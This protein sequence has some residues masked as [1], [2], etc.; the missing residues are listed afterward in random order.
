M[1]T[2]NILPLEGSSIIKV[3]PAKL[4]AGKV[5]K[6]LLVIFVLSWISM[7]SSCVVAVPHERY[8][9]HTIVVEQEYR[10]E[11]HDNG[12]HKGWYKEKGNKHRRDDDHH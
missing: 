1:K 9:R 6:S 11:H 3:I 5:I 10:G 8:H 7:L 2:S 4:V 12:K